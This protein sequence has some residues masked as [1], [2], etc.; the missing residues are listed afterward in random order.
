MKISGRTQQLIQGNRGA[1]RF[2]P[3]HR[4]SGTNQYGSVKSVG[5]EQYV[6]NN[7]KNKGKNKPGAGSG[8]RRYQDMDYSYERMQLSDRL[9]DMNPAPP[10]YSDTLIRW[11]L[12]MN[13][14][15]PVPEFTFDAYEDPDDPNEKDEPNDEPND[16]PKDEPKD[17]DDEEP[18]VEMTKEEWETQYKNDDGTYKYPTEVVDA[19]LSYDTENPIARP[20]SSAVYE[21]FSKW[22]MYEK[23]VTFPNQW[24]DEQTPFTIEKWND[25]E[26][27]VNF[28]FVFEYPKGSGSKAWFTLPI[29]KYDPRVPQSEP[30]PSPDVKTLEEWEK[31]FKDGDKSYVLPKDLFPPNTF[32]GSASYFKGDIVLNDDQWNYISF[33]VQSLKPRTGWNGSEEW[34]M[35]PRNT[36]FHINT[37][38]SNWLSVGYRLNPDIPFSSQDY[39]AFGVSVNLYL[40]R[41][42]STEPDPVP[43]PEPEPSPSPTKTDEEIFR[44]TYYNESTGYLNANV[45]D[46]FKKRGHD[47]TLNAEQIKFLTD[48]FIYLWD[49]P[50]PEIPTGKVTFGDP[51]DRGSSYALDLYTGN[52]PHLKL[53]WTLS[54]SK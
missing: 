9:L 49:N 24:F 27:I 39:K 32:A 51:A 53:W 28:K 54:I 50:N 1:G 20:L 26:G 7:Q 40:Q 25:G 34:I 43:V 21:Y 14:Q 15:V 36:V 42:P 4:P 10:P 19:W 37:S 5:D 47:L 2:F 38:I 33:L 22:L 3:Y 46:L 41:E 6:K 45:L 16:E 11:D 13:P 23:N 12:D 44:D 30:E 48:Y 18:K 8:S 35:P 29:S 52:Y 17:D 31:E